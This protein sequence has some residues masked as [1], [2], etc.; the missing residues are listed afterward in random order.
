[1]WDSRVVV[2][3]T[4]HIRLLSLTSIRSETPG[5]DFGN[6]SV[7]HLAIHRFEKTPTMTIVSIKSSE[8]SYLL[9]L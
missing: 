3:V 2:K 1:M 7:Y 8:Q 4:N 9:S 5:G 6:G